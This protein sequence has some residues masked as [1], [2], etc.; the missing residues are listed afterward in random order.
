MTALILA[1]SKFFGGTVVQAQQLFPNIPMIVV[2]TYGD[3][4][5]NTVYSLAPRVNPIYDAHIQ[6]ELRSIGMHN[7]IKEQFP[8]EGYYS[9]QQLYFVLQKLSNPQQQYVPSQNNL[10]HWLAGMLEDEVYN[11]ALFKLIEE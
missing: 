1:L 10:R 6:N 8:G 3:D 2:E 9:T 4:G 5:C 11:C 7:K